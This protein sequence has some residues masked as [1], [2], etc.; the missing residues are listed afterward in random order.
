MDGF[1]DS[2][3]FSSQ[4]LI[5]VDSQV[6]NYQSIIA[7][8]DSSEIVILDSSSSGI[9]QMIIFKAGQTP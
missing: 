2:T 9:E 6:E 1:I 3:D 5:F 4:N 7:D 8:L